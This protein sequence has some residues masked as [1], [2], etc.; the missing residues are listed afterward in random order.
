MD[1]GKDTSLRDCYTTEELV[2][3]FI[4]SDGQLQVSGNDS[5]LLVVTSGV[6]SQLEDLSCKVLED[7]SEVH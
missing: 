1:E 6:S 2:E 5:G 4:V 7:G 3:L